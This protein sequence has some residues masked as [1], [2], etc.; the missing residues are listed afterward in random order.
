MRRFSAARSAG[1]DVRA[2]GPTAGVRRDRLPGVEGARG[3]AALSVLA[4]H[5]W[6][7]G[8]SGLGAGGTALSYGWLGVPLFF[9][10]SGLLLYR[11]FARAIVAG[12][13]LPS[14]RRYGRARFLR[15]FPA[16]WLVLL[17]C[18]PFL[19]PRFA[20][21]ASSWLTRGVEQLFL[22]QTWFSNDWDGLAPAWTLAIEI[23]F[24]AVLPLIV[25][26]SW[27][28]ARRMPTRNGRALTQMLALAPLIPAA[29]AYQHVALHRGWPV[30]LP[31][32]IDEF[33]IGM[34]LAVALELPATRQGLRRAWLLGPTAILA[35]CLAFVF[36]HTGPDTNGY[37]GMMFTL[38]VTVGFALLLARVLLAEGHAPL[39]GRLLSSGPLTWLGMVSYGIYL[40]HWPVITI[41]GGN[42][43]R[44][45]SWPLFA[46]RL[47]LVLAVTLGLAALS[48]Y[49]LE[50]RALALKDARLGRRTRTPARLV[51][52]E[53]GRP[54]H[55]G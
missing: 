19:D 20:H 9:V 5:V 13:S 44:H 34:L 42:A 7:R 43:W 37:T 47:A 41:V 8:G 35:F 12:S 6:L 23:T 26:A 55:R 50:R 14:F 21:S 31:E 15:I 1:H 2:R 29:F 33:A 51:P 36:K 53:P 54:V 46:G 17:C 28:L 24:Y 40:W 3:V 30:A 38:L 25:L 4:Y 39:V 10:L 22:V 32:Y 18:V 11:P 52:L 48:W 27:A 49:G 45:D 16:Y